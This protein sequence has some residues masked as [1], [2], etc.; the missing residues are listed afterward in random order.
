MEGPCCACLV[1]ARDDAIVKHKKAP[2][3]RRV[4]VAVCRPCYPRADNGLQQSRLRPLTHTLTK[5]ASRCRTVLLHTTR[6]RKHPPAAHL[7]RPACLIAFSRRFAR[8]ARLQRCALPRRQIRFR[9]LLTPA[10]TM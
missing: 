2:T 1:S 10:I 8:R 9:Q 5:G 4:A 6:H 3:L 7:G